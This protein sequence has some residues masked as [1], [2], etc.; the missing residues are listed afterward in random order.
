MDKRRQ[1]V[2]ENQEKR[3]KIFY[4]KCPRAQEI[5]REI[6]STSI[7]V[8]KQ[9]FSG[10]ANVKEQLEKLKNYN[11]NLQK[12]LSE[13]LVKNGFPEN[14]LEEWYKCNLCKDTGYINGKMCS[15]MKQL[16]RDTAYNELNSKSPL[17]LCDFST[18]DVSLY[19]GE[20][21]MGQK[22]S[23]IEKMSKIFEYCKKYAEN[24]S[25]N[26]DNLLLRGSTGLGKT[27]LS[28][29]IA[30]YVI[31]KGFGV[32]YFS[33]PNLVNQLEKERFGDLSD[34]ENTEE[35]LTDCDLL[36]LDDMGTEHNSAYA[37]SAIYNI[38]NTRIMVGKPTII[39]TNLTISDL[40]EEYSKRLVSRIMGDFTRL[41]FVGKDIRQIKKLKG[42]I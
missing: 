21:Q 16:L 26:S 30:K 24:F 7:R 11:L 2:F 9:V 20:V 36:I 15:C 23:P 29:A 14:F 34:N 28:L 10:K 5:E 17:S 41:E 27:H 35:I 18:F 13:L 40:Q 33:A 12:E 39:N 3:K 1:L 37:T 42:L 31:S 32:I 38:I 6:A 8:A 22:T 4:N 25:L 19:S